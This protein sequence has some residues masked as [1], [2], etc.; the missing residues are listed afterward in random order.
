MPNLIILTNKMNRKPSETPKYLYLIWWAIERGEE[1]RI[2]FRERMREAEKACLSSWEQW[3]EYQRK[4]ERQREA[5]SR[6]KEAEGTVK[7]LGIWVV[8]FVLI[9]DFFVVN[10]LD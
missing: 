2:R 4:N 9:C 3:R 8:L 1:Q 7:F 6:E 10:F 5:K